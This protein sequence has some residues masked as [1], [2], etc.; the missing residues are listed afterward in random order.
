MGN[1]TG[2]K[3]MFEIPIFG[4]IPVTETVTNSWIIMAVIVAV[5]IYLSSGLKKIPTGKQIIAEKIVGMLYNFVEETMG[6]GYLRFA[7]YIG[8][9]FTLSIL[10]SLSSL[11]GMRP[12]TADLSTT[13]G[14]ALMTFFTV[15][16]MNIKYNGVKG[17]LK[18]FAEPVPFILPINIVG[19]IANPISMSFRHFGNIAAGMVITSLLYGALAA[20][21]SFVLGWI[22]NSF[23]NSI[24]IFQLGIPAVLSIYFDLFT[25]FLQ[26]Y[27]ICMLTMV[28]VSSAGGDKAARE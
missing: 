2:P 5:C 7:P 24:P 8:A 19:E 17:W 16:F 15:Q 23:I 14:W 27:I 28:F 12:L 11:L 26:A 25:S 3:I 4:G 13:L 6:K 22:P 20:L 10:G 18:G 21:S 1:V 9:L